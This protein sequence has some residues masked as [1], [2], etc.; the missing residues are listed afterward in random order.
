[1]P[2]E[3]LF[4]DQFAFWA[5]GD[6]HA[7]SGYGD[8]PLADPVEFGSLPLSNFACRLGDAD[9]PA[10]KR[11]WSERIALAWT[12]W[13]SMAAAMWTYFIPL[14]VL[15]GLLLLF[16]AFALLARVRGG[17]YVRPVIAL[18]SKVP[19]FR[20]WMTKAWKASLERQNPALASAV[21][22]LERAGVG[23]DP[24]R[25][26]AALS[27]LTAAE[28]RAYLEAAGEQGMMPEPTN[29]AERRRLEKLQ[30]KTQR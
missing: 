15:G 3:E 9:D 18:I 10:R 8:P 17:R 26:Q 5:T 2:P 22:K 7:A 19:L 25:A 20:R 30:K 6:A 4:A 28:R 1:V 24:Q 23:R 21:E 29:R 16:G 11:G 12:R 27:R 13:S 14:Y